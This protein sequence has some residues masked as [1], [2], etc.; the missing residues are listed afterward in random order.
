MSR[1]DGRFL[2]GPFSQLLSMFSRL[3]WQIRTPPLFTDHEDLEHDF[4]VIPRALLRNLVVRAWSW[5]LSR[6]VRH[7]TSMHDLDGLEFSLTNLDFPRL[8]PLDKART[9]ALQ[10]GAYMFGAEHCVHDMQRDGMCSI[11]H[12]P[13]T[14]AHRVCACPRHARHRPADVDVTA[15]WHA[16]PE[17]LRSHLL[18]PANPYM[19]PLRAQLHSLADA[20]GHFISDVATCERQHLFTDGSCIQGDFQGL[21]VAAWGV[22]NASTG[23]V[24]SC[25]PVLGI[26]QSAPRAELLAV[27][28][29]LQWILFMNVWATIWSDAQHVVAQVQALLDGHALE[30]NPANADLWR[31]ISELLHML[32]AGTFSIRHVP[33]HLDDDK[34]E[35]PFEDWVRC[36]NDHADRIAV[37][38]N[39]NRPVSF[40]DLHAAAVE[41]QARTAAAIRMWRTIYF[42]I[43]EDTLGTASIPEN[44]W[45][46]DDE[47][48]TWPV[49]WS[50][51]SEGLQDRLPINWQVM[52]T[53]KCR[54][55]PADFALSVTRTLLDIDTELDR[56]CSVSWLELLFLLMHTGRVQ[57]PARDLQT[58]AWQSAERVPFRAPELT[59]AT[60]LRL[61]RE[62]VRT[63]VHVVQLDGILCDYVDVTF[64]GISMRMGGI[65]LG[66]DPIKLGEARNSVYS[67]TAAKPIRASADLARPF[68]G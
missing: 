38:T 48:P 58:G 25:A 61:L 24:A 41:H 35:S 51:R 5:R 60:Q 63:F 12:V 39:M 22:V 43:A 16:T 17:C 37:L 52:L 14:R 54:A 15:A 20:T 42:G 10:S 59:V 11:C 29:A 34:T 3:S 49:V 30:L 65:C 23:A 27:I 9:R 8:S 6:S 56:T 67:F 2:H 53:G 47:G 64:L 46:Q 31:R 55:W 57:F 36:W 44:T 28:S 45:E 1:Y 13:D 40:V 26:I 33:S 4:L 32:P 50:P 66:A 19:A 68:R 62:V 18:P 21:E 7:R